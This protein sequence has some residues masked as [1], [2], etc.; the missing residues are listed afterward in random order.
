MTTV[1]NDL[2]GLELLSGRLVT[3]FLT[4]A[5]ALEG[6]KFLAAGSIVKVTNNPNPDMNGEYVWDGKQL[7]KTTNNILEK[8]KEQT[9]E[10][11]QEA[12]ETEV[13]TNKLLDLLE[14][15][16][17]GSM[18][19]RR[20]EQRIDKI[21]SITKNIEDLKSEVSVIE[22]DIQIKVSNARW[23][24]EQVNLRIENISAEID[25]DFSEVKQQ[26][27]DL[28]N[29]VAADFQAIRDEVDQKFVE[30]DNIRVDLNKEI[31]DRITA[32]NAE[33]AARLEAIQLLNDGLTQEIQHRIDGDSALLTNIENYKVSNDQSIA[34]V[35]SRIDVVVQD[36]AANATK[37]DA[38]DARVSVAEDDAQQALT[39]S[40][41]AVSK[42]NALADDV[43]AFAT[44]VDSV[45][46][47][48]QTAVDDAGRALTNS[49]T[50]M[51]QAQAASDAANAAASSVTVV[52][53]KLKNKSTTY[54]RTTEPLKAD[55]PDLSV[56]DI[57]IN[58]SNFNEQK[59]WDGGQWVISSDFRVGNHAVAINTINATM[60]DLDGKVTANTNAI[61]SLEVDLDGKVD[62][63]AFNQLT[64]TVTQ[65]GDDI[66]TNA[67]DIT[68]LT[69]KVDGKADA[70]AL[71]DLQ[72]QVVV[73]GDQI[74][75][76]SS[77]ITAVDA[78]I[79]GLA[80]GATNLLSDTELAVTQNRNYLLYR[81]SE[82][83]SDI[84]SG[85]EIT[86]SFDIKSNEA[87]SL[88]VYS[89]NYS[90][91]W[92]FTKNIPINGGDIW[93]RHYVT[94]T[95]TRDT[96]NN[97]GQ[98]C[99]EFHLTS[100]TAILSAR[101]VKIERGNIATDWTP[102]P[103]DLATSRALEA[104]KATVTTHDGLI[105]S[106]GQ[107][108]T[109]LEQE[110]DGKASSLVVDE[111][112]STVVQQGNQ[113]T[114]QGQAIQSLQ[115]EVD[116]KA[117]SSALSAL[118]SRVT[119]N[120]GEI[121]SQGQSIT[122]VKATLGALDSDSLVPDYNLATPSQ[123]MSHY[124]Y[125]MEGYFRQT[126]T[127]KIGSS[128]FVKDGISPNSASCW[129][130]NNK[131]LPNTRA[132]KVSMWIR[133]SANSDNNSGRNRITVLRGG[134]DGQF[135]I[136]NYSYGGAFLV[137]EPDVWTYVEQII[138]L[139]SSKDTYP[140]IKLGFALGHNAT[141]G[142][143]EA[144]GFKV[145]P[146][147]ESGDM[148]STVAT[149]E[150]VSSLKATVTQQGGTISSQGQA[151]TG[152][153]NEIKDKADT[154]AL[155]E[156][157]TEV[158]EN[159]T[160]IDTNAKSIQKLESTVSV[161]S[162]E[163]KITGTT[164]SLRS[165]RA[166]NGETYDEFTGAD[167]SDEPTA[168]SGKVIRVSQPVSAVSE[169]FVPI[170]PNKLYRI[171]YRFRRVQGD[172]G[173][174]LSVVC[175]NADKTK[176]IMQSDV[177]TQ[178]NSI[179]NSLYFIANQKPALGTWVE[180]VAYIGGKSG[181]ASNGSFGS[182]TNPR[183]FPSKAAF[184]RVGILPNYSGLAG[185]QDFDYIIV[186]DFEA[187][188]LGEANGSA[189]QA[190][191]VKV[192]SNTNAIS[193]QATSI[194]KLQTDLNVVDGKVQNKADS[195][196][197]QALDSKV[198]LI[199]GRVTANTSSI[200]A[201]NSK[202]NTIEG[203]LDTKA[204]ASVLQN[205]S[206]KAET[207][208]AVATGLETYNAN[209]RV[210]TAN[211]AVGFLN[212]EVFTG[213]SGTTIVRESGLSKGLLQGSLNPPFKL[214]IS[215]GSNIIK[216]TP[217]IYVS[218]NAE[219]VITAKVKNVG[220]ESI[221]INLNGFGHPTT[222]S[223]GQYVWLKGQPVIAAGEEVEIAVHGKFRSDYDW[224][225]FQLR[226]VNSSYTKL[227][228]LMSDIM[229]SEGSVASTWQPAYAET[230]ASIEANATATQT[231]D[232]K[233]TNID[234]RVT[235][236]TSD[237]SSMKA[238]I[239]GKADASALNS[240]QTTVTQQGNQITSQGQA[241]TSVQSGVG[242]AT[243]LAQL[244][245]NAKMV[246]S[247][248]QFK[249]S[250]SGITAYDNAGTGRVKVERLARYT[251]DN[252]TTS[253]HQVNVTV[254]SGA[255]P[256]YGGFARG[257]LSRANA[258]FVV[259]Y[260]LKLPVG[261]ELSPHGNA[262]GT[263]GSDSFIGSVQGTGKYETYTRVIRC[264]ASGSFGYTGHVSIR[265]TALTGTQT[266]TFP[267][268]QIEIYDCTDFS[269]ADQS[270]LDAITANSTAITNL[271]TRTTTVEGKVD[272][273]AS[274]ISGLQSTVA[275]KADT[276][277]L[278][279]LKTQVTQQGSD[280]AS[281]GSS[282]TQV[283]SRIDSVS[284]DS[285]TLDYETKDPSSWKSHYSYDM[286]QYF[287]TTSTGKIG[288]N[289]FHKDNTNPSPCYNYNNKGVPNNRK[290]RVSM[291]V[292]R[293]SAS[294]DG[295]CGFNCRLMSP[296]GSVGSYTSVK[297]LTIPANGVWTFVTA[298]YER[299]DFD[300]YPMLR[301]GFYLG[302]S[303]TTG[304]WQM[305]GFKV[306]PILTTADMDSSVASATA[307]NS[308]DTKVTQI[309]GKVTSQATSIQQLDTKVGQ[310][311]ASIQTQAQSIDGIRTEWTM[312]MDVNGYVSGIGAI[313]TGTTS[314][315]IIR[316]DKFAIANPT[317]TGKKYGFVYQSSS[318]TLPNGTVIPAGLYVDNLILGAINA[319]KINASELSA[320]TAKLGTLVT[321]KN[322][323]N[324]NGARMVMTGSLITVYDDSNRVR[325]KLGLW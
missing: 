306:E 104:L 252:P 229:V 276:S 13:N 166:S 319:E 158:T 151:I 140:Q 210:G 92:K 94:V 42:V 74:S 167:L 256:N 109:G 93:E 141:Q 17:T 163:T 195:S 231:V 39:N 296:D 100:A 226:P 292:R 320:I 160:G 321:Y 295:S 254:S 89:T 280:I 253:T 7:V 10:Q 123:W 72:S 122:G 133:R 205:Y 153:Q 279:Q 58:P 32:I 239:A 87:G 88:R 62:S 157:K 135:N 25:V 245:T 298:E 284:A 156:L 217:Q 194:S 24:L 247:D 12:L 257:I 293:S 267:I 144:Q 26:I 85:G 3:L 291:W 77:A 19:D 184:F 96:A 48:V 55:Y 40:A 290:Y 76:N 209:I 238:S 289:V 34:N 117:S 136:A 164:D 303:G 193:S 227:E 73:Q 204:D 259:K 60:T 265:G 273:Q 240:L 218:K 181:G 9:E 149:A 56:G 90:A 197:V 244:I 154:T 314:E 97:S 235:A 325:V 182:K 14:G 126:A 114:S 311:T 316:A 2:N 23:E 214:T 124:G 78:R 130:Y 47:S 172:G 116:G 307:L 180:G 301:F 212:G 277:A 91:D 119:D 286:S 148:G 304:Y 173:V 162:T 230:Q 275:G 57:W 285:L 268:A 168:V 299:T 300:T 302:H 206:T 106:Q 317:G 274:Q 95:P 287:K 174:Y 183:T 35:Q 36:T 11:I 6:V 241:I 125:P 102:S 278:N 211:H 27:I 223:L 305:Q 66:A 246:N 107:A 258:V 146:V 288:G 82:E 198:T 51:T 71:S 41:S 142:V 61:Q 30:V 134:T 80:I 191:D 108:I 105:A 188:A 16:I 113:I 271:T 20:L 201:L 170:D 216:T 103:K 111:L 177:E 269:P 132:Y 29:Q 138:D 308:L 1:D 263:G 50:A 101:M 79:D 175:T 4:Y 309:D 312:K 225:Q 203:E 152:L 65:Q 310:N 250:F 5:D 28:Q 43:S 190:M 131:T 22:N 86:I 127:G 53:A 220:T 178:P 110:V 324:P 145:T 323:S 186:E 143:W 264:G 118:E 84:Y 281:L 236:N 161:V 192:Q 128:V 202:V 208:Q 21:P 233:V 59:R 52:E 147:L 207:T 137:P 313:N 49:A 248:P 176:N 18:L 222:G 112:K 45:E 266:M 64:A 196:V 67:Q 54:R 120:E 165:L 155:N 99:L 150:S 46:A 242:D 219:V 318:Q 249:E 282:L 70:K 115:Q 322:P 232:A 224:I 83:L 169:M 129:N 139:V 8:A 200:N 283:E 75:A 228:I 221:L 44:R 315:F 187:Q 243:K 199:D 33:T 38:V 251:V 98:S 297:G 69:T 159:A 171:K 63:T 234:G 81:K 260:L 255:N 179:S 185:I 262:I 294:T 261:Y 237:I 272:T 189:I 270:V 213:Y 121:T 31:Q 215:G 37:I 68:A 15:Q